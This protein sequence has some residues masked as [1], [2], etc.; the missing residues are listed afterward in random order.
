MPRRLRCELVAATLGL[1]GRGCAGTPLAP[2]ASKAMLGARFDAGGTLSRARPVLTFATVIPQAAPLSSKDQ[3]V[4]GTGAHGPF[5]ADIPSPPEALPIIER[6]VR[7]PVWGA[8]RPAWR[9]IV[10]TAGAAA[11]SSMAAVL[12]L[13]LSLAVLGA[14]AGFGMRSLF[15]ATPAEPTVDLAAESSSEQVLTFPTRAP[16]PVVAAVG[17]PSVGAPAVAPAPLATGVAAPA[18]RAVP[19]H[20]AIAAP[21][22]PHSRPSAVGAHPR[23]HGSRARP[24]T[25]AARGHVLRH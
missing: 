5:A 17:T 11:R 25:S 16:A 22:A 1:A 24:G 2:L 21:L 3:S 13:G 18:V 20:A 15:G 7:R 8:L 4:V 9:P 23:A 19:P 10:R 14:A 6:I 12:T